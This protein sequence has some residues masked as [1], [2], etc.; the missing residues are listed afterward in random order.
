MNRIRTHDDLLSHTLFSSVF[1]RPLGHPSRL[2]VDE[3]KI[4]RPLVMQVKMERSRCESMHRPLKCANSQRLRSGYAAAGFR[5]VV[6][7]VMVAAA[8]GFFIVL[9]IKGER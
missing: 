3:A 4:G 5:W 7:W 9:L 1:I 8:A 2:A 6:F